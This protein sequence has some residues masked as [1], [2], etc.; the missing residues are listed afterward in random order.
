M[1][2]PSKSKSDAPYP[3]PVEDCGALTLASIAKLLEENREALTLDFKET[4]A[5]LEHKLDR[6]HDTVAAH[7]VTIGE[8]EKNA[9]Q[10]DSRLA[11]ME[12]NC[13]KLSDSNTKLLAKVSDLES[14]YRRHHIRVVGLPE[15]IETQQQPIVFY[16][17]MLTEVFGHI[18]D[19]PPECEW[20][21]RIPSAKPQPGQRPRSVI[22][23]LHK[24]LV[25]EKIIREAR[26]KRGQLK[27]QSHP[28]SV[29]EDYPPEIVA[30]RKEYR[31]VMSE[32][33]KRGLRPTLLFPAKL[34]NKLKEGAAPLCREAETNECSEV[35]NF[36]TTSPPSNTKNQSASPPTSPVLGPTWANC[37]LVGELRK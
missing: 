20:A 19:S 8:L 29:Y 14:R 32:L 1:P 4:F 24:Y 30:Q 31:E 23:R 12:T 9:T 3:A 34:F 2:K 21:H 16:S 22:I 10:Q 27:F 11:T 26:A 25:K 33:Y 7:T 36:A 28:I 15:S 6:I 17:K 35:S 18:L 37:C 5:K 13:V